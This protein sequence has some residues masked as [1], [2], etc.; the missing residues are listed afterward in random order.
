MILDTAR[1][2]YPPYWVDIKDF[3]NSVSA[4][5][6]GHHKTR[7]LMVVSENIE[8]FTKLQIDE[9]GYKKIGI[10][11]KSQ[12]PESLIQIE[13]IK[14]MSDDYFDSMIGAFVSDNVFLHILKYIHDLFLIYGVEKCHCFNMIKEKFENKIENVGTCC[15][16]G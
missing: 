9:L 1:F 4:M 2:K 14:E 11:L 8:D 13:S 6:K 3:Y 7:G 10:N 15:E 12:M 16:S 5:I